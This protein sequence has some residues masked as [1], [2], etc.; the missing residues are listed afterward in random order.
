MAKYIIISN[1][2]DEGART[3]KKNP[4]RVKE[5]N[6]ELRY[7]DVKVLDQYAVLGNFDFLTIVEA[8]DETKIT[9]AVVEI[10]SR[11]SIKTVTFKAIPIDEFIES[12]K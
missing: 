10:A 12:L 3:L 6:D 1:L 2:T 5:V 4:E 11:G 8:E 7:M 9:K